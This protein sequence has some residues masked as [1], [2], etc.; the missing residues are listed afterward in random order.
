MSIKGQGEQ[1]VATRKRA[2]QS[3]PYHIRVHGHQ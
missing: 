2:Y 3:R 1:G